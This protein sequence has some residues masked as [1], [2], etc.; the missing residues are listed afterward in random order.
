MKNK[1]ITFLIIFSCFGFS[2]SYFPNEASAS[3]R[4][5]IN[6]GS[7][8]GSSSK[9]KSGIIKSIDSEVPETVKGNTSLGRFFALIRK[10]ILNIVLIISVVMLVRIGIRMASAR[11][12]PDEFKKAW[13]HFVYLILGIFLV[14][15]SWGI[16]N[17]VTKLNIF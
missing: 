11:G 1:I 7:D 14:F 3:L 5:E 15:A 12:N 13:L 8:G 4:I 10:N 9:I 6:K 16:V 17:I 2:A